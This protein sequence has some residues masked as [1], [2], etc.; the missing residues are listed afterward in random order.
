MAAELLAVHGDKNTHKRG[1]LI[2]SQISVFV[3]GINIIIE[4]DDSLRD[5]KGHKN[6]KAKE[7]AETVFAV[8]KGIHLNNMARSCGAKTVV[9]EQFNVYCGDTGGFGFS[10]PSVDIADPIP[11]AISLNEPLIPPYVFSPDTFT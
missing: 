2:S 10:I 3:N 8:G 6:P 9:S 7:G 1:G 11:L 4:G 5:G